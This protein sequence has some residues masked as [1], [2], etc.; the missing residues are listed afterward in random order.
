MGTVQIREATTDDIP[1]IV[2]LYL[3]WQ[4][5]RGILPDQLIAPQTADHISPYFNGNK[6]N[7]KYI[8]AVGEK[9]E[10][11]GVCYLDLLFKSLQTIRIGDFIVDKQYRHHGIGKKLLEYIT[12]YS[13]END[14]KKLWLWTQEELVEAI[15]FYQKNGF[16]IEGKQKSQFL[17][18]DAIV[19]GLVL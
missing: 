14:I 9:D 4:E 8:V 17:G 7:R 16:T 5:F 18:K 1:Q 12:N 3:G 19:L 10:I 11:L 6:N 15:E 13:K 2:N